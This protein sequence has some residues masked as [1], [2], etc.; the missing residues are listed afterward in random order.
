MSVLMSQQ[1]VLNTFLLCCP[2][3]DQTHALQENTF[4][5]F[6]TF[7]MFQTVPKSQE[8]MMS[9]FHFSILI[10]YM[11]ECFACVCLCTTCVQYLRKPEEGIGSPGLVLHILVSSHVGVGNLEE[12]PVLVTAEP[13]LWP[14]EFV[15]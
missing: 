15:S 11:Y 5:I 8:A 12:Q 3:G 14:H 2:T 1:D 9:L 10:V 7:K 13:C 4:S 6:L